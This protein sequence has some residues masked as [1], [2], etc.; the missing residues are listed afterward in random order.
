MS[1]TT[2][3]ISL[4]GDRD[5]NQ[6]RVSIASD[7]DAALL[8]VVDGM[9]GHSQ[10]ERAADMA[11]QTLLGEFW[12]IPH[13]VF[14]PL[15]FLHLSLSR[16][17]DAVV[18]LGVD[19][20]VEERPR[21]TCAVCLVQE[22]RAYWAH[23]GD[24]RIYHIRKKQVLERTRDHSHVEVLLREG[25]IS[26]D[27]IHVHPMRNFVECCLGGSSA[28]PEMSVGRGRRLTTGDVLLLCSDGFWAGLKDQDI[29]HAF[30]DGKKTVQD[31]L[32]GLGKEAVAMSAPTSDNTTAAAMVWS[33]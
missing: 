33:G 1:F 10:G 27:E 17:H 16:A 12:E 7:D 24:S 9:G 30:V 5:D 29:A 11:L 4:L 13:P 2:G 8:I 26:E 23:V 6:D 15:G 14:D 20:K 19:L 22:G 28:L 31:V 32:D 25:L 21:A 3:E 18:N